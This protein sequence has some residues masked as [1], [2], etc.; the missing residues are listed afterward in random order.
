MERLRQAFAP[1]YPI[2][3]FMGA[4]GYIRVAYAACDMLGHSMGEPRKPIRSLR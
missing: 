1:M 4:K 3:E 2:C